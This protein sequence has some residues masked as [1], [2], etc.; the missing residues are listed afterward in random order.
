MKKILIA[1]GT[2]PEIIKLAPVIKAL[3]EGE[4]QIKIL[5]TGQ[6]RELIEPMLT[7]FDIRPDINL[8]VMK[9]EQDL[10]NLTESLTGKMKDVFEFEKPDYVIVQGDTTSAFIA[11][12]SAFYLKIPVLH[13]EAGLRSH[14]RYYPFPEEGNRA[15]ISKL[16]TIHFA[17]TDLNKKN[18]I[19]E[20]IP[21]EQIFV[22]GNTVIDALELIRSSKQFSDSKPDIL[23]DIPPEHKLVV[24]TAHRRENHGK[25][26]SDILKAVSQLL[27]KNET[28]EVVFPA[29]PSPAVQQAIKNS[30]VQSE[31]FH[32]TKP[33]GYLAFLHI[34]QRADLIL[35]DSGG[36]QEEAATLGKPILVL[37]N[38]TERQELID[39]GL[40]KLVGSDPDKILQ[41]A[42]EYLKNNIK[43]N[44]QA[45]FG[46][47][48]AS[49]QI[50][51]VLQSF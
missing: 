18:L 36:I 51:E 47:G 43:L 50:K 32:I 44:P 33:F 15:L 39:S 27:N 1:F 17:P 6:H 48:E 19:K 2:R 4:F 40:G 34:L 35:T 30:D 29:H 13:V 46:N 22:T 28:L 8:N 20:G 45:L 37:R 26:F 41:T 5:H 11:A 38:E 21:V 31:R 23:Q 10:F 7:L 9:P 12:L 14:N 42:E 3:S 25:P 16:A 24:L 49:M